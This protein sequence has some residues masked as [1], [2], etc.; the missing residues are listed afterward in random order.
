MLDWL[1]HLF[2]NE[3]RPMTVTF[4]DQEAFELGG[5]R[6]PALVDGVQVDCTISFEA[7]QNSFAILTPD[8]ALPMFRANRL[9][10]ETLA[11]AMI[12]AGGVQ[13]GELKIESVDFVSGH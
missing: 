10:I 5:V 7:L 8:E 4:P 2:T 1:K 3:R 12:E 13:N 9:E 11:E 6:F